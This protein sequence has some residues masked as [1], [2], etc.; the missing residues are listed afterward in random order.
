MHSYALCV[1]AV[2]ACVA[3]GQQSVVDT[4]EDGENIGGWMNT[5]DGGQTEGIVEEGG[6]PGAF[7]FEIESS[8]G[9]MYRAIAPGTAFTGDYRA[10]GVTKL[11]IDLRVLGVNFTEIALP[12]TLMLVRAPNGVALDPCCEHLD[13]I[14]AFM[15]GELNPKIAEGWKTFSYEIPADAKSLPSG[16]SFFDTS[17]EEDPDWNTL[18]EGVD[19]IRVY[20]GTLD[21]ILPFQVWQTGIDNATIVF[22]CVADFD[23][24]GRLSVLDF[25]AFQ[26]AFMA[27]DASA[28]VTGDGVLNVVDFI[29]YQELFVAGCG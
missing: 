26:G 14:G 25:I 9:P 7:L 11:S 24:D 6:N 28:D 12:T 18:I 2:F 1:L 23:G 3:H 10:R 4:F 13:I 21:D 8:V 20:F 19:E 29:G 22:E 16:W 15:E 27:G 17:A 5:G